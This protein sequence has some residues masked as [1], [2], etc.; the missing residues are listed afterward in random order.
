[1]AGLKRPGLMACCYCTLS[2]EDKD[3]TYC[4]V[5]WDALEYDP[6]KSARYRMMCNASEARRK[7]NDLA[8]AANGGFYDL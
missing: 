3:G 1:M 7:A 6:Y 8:V 4:P 5:N 2:R